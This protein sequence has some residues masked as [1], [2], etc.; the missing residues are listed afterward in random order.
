MP[1]AKPA[2]ATSAFKSPAAKRSTILNGQPKNTKAPIITMKA[3]KNLVIGAEPPLG[4]NSP[5]SKL[6]INEPRIKPII[7]GLTY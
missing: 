4:L 3:M 5:F 7:S 6:I 2:R 1:A